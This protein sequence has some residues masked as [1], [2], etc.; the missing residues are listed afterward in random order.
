MFVSSSEGDT[1]GDAVPTHYAGTSYSG[2]LDRG[3]T[4]KEVAM[5]SEA[6]DT[7]WMILETLALIM[8][9]FWTLVVVALAVFA[10]WTAV[11]SHVKTSRSHTHILAFS[12][13]HHDPPPGSRFDPR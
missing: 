8:G 13:M 9:G 3:E 11:H 5:A 10:A 7:L 1:D 4:R 12:G 6:G 2:R